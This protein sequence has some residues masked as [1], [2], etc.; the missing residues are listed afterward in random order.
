ME[1]V[2]RGKIHGYLKR[3][4]TNKILEWARNPEEAFLFA[5]HLNDTDIPWMEETPAVTPA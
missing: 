4:W 1:L 5:I 3:Y 2:K